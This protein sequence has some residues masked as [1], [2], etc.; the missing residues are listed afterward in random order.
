MS[1][2]K[3]PVT[4]LTGYLG[5]G[6]TVHLSRVLSEDHRHKF[7]GLVN[8]LDTFRIEPTSSSVTTRTPSR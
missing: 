4:V 6:K 2:G 1:K 5:T 7:A 8:E 3:I